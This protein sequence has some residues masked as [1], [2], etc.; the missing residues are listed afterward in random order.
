MS[1]LAGA[2]AA[3]GSSFTWAYASARYTTASQTIGAVRV[4]LAR[5]LVAAPIYCVVTAV[6]H[7]SAATTPV[8]SAHVAWLTSETLRRAMDVALDNARRLQRGA[9]LLHRVA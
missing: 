5:V 3:L 8:T 4:N 2:L 9:D 6:L 1:S 7:G